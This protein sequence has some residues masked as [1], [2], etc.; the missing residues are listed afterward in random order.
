MKIYLDL[1][2]FV[3]E[4]RLTGI[5]RAERSLIRHWPGPIPLSPCAYDPAT[6]TLRSL[7]TEL[8]SAIV[9]EAKY[10]GLAS[11]TRRLASYFTLGNPIALSG[12]R[13]L[14]AE[15][16]SDAG[17]AAYY[18]DRQQ[19]P[20][21]AFW[22]VYD[23]LP[24]LRPDWFSIGAPR[25]MMP[26]LQALRSI[27]H[28][29]FISQQVRED[30]LNRVIRLPGAGPVIPMGADGLGLERQSFVPSRRQIVMLGTI[31]ARKNTLAALKAFQNLWAEDVSIGLTLIGEI[32]AHA[33]EER[34]FIQSLAGQPLLRYLADLPDEGVRDALRTA[35]AMLFP[36]EGE[37]YGIPP[38]EGLQAGIPAI[39]A[40]SLPALNGLPAFGQIRLETVNPDTITAALRH[41]M[42]DNAAAFLWAGA[43]QL[44]L[45]TWSGFAQQ[46]ASWLHTTPADPRGQRIQALAIS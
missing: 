3:R 5:Q 13:I 18:E 25:Y 44:S 36:S 41:L 15:L 38:M 28:V 43:A 17:R 11:E 16:F 46:V 24:W 21:E 8:L 2:Q 14:C 35:R 6:H 34:A 7:P 39:V 37:G 26:Y 9:Q 27:P 31:E 42:T 10:G 32:S 22:L 1:S 33:S 20:A 45:P 19:N 4:P 30:Y 29:A 23:F 12:A 40:A